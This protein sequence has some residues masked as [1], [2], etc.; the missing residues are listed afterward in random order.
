MAAGRGI[1]SVH[2]DVEADTSGV[3]QEVVKAFKSAGELGGKAAKDAIND[4]LGEIGG[5]KLKAALKKIREQIERGLD[6]LD[7]KLEFDEAKLRADIAKLNAYLERQDLDL[8]VDPDLENF[9]AELRALDAY[10][11]AKHPELKVD[12]TIESLQE[13]IRALQAR[14]DAADLDVEV[15]PKIDKTAKARTDAALKKNFSEVGRESGD[16]FGKNF[17]DSA[18]RGISTRWKAI[19]AGIATLMEPAAVLA[20]GLAASITSVLSSAVFAVGAG[21]AASTPLLVGLI[22]AI[23]GVVLA[24]EG[25][26]DAM[27]AIAEEDAEAFAAALEKLSPAAAEFATA[28][29]GVW[30]E[31]KTLRTGLQEDLFEGLADRFTNM[32]ESVIPQLEVGLGALV[33]KINEF[34]GSLMDMLAEADIGSVLEGLAPAIDLVLDGILSLASALMPFIEAATPAATQLAAMFKVWADNVADFD[35][36][37][38]QQFLDEGMDS[39]RLWLDLLGGV[40]S[41]LGT[42]FE[43]GK[44]SGDGFLQ[45]LNEI[46]DK[47]NE[48][49]TSVEGQSALEEFFENGR[50]VMAALEPLLVGLAQGIHN[51]V[52]EDSIARFEELTET[53]GEILPMV[54]TLFSLFS[55]MGILQGFADLLLVVMEALEPIVPILESFTD[56]ISEAIGAGIEAL[57]PAIEAFVDALAVLLP[58]LEPVIPVIFQLVTLKWQVIITAIGALVDVFAQLAPVVADLFTVMGP[59]IDTVLSTLG[60]VLRESAPLLEA[61]MKAFT[62]LLPAVEPLIEV[63][64]QLVSDVLVALAPVIT[65]LGDAL[66]QLMPS[67]VELIDAVRPIIPLLGE[68][69]VGAVQILMNLLEP[70]LPVLTDI[71]DAFLTA[72]AP[73]I[74]PLVDALVALSAALAPVIEELGAQM[75]EQIQTLAPLLPPLAELFIALLE[76]ITPLIPIVTDLLLVQNRLMTEGLQLIMPMLVDIIGIFTEFANVLGEVIATVTKFVDWVIDQFTRLFNVL[77]GNSIIPDLINGITEW[78]EKLMDLIDIVTA[79]FDG[80]RSVVETVFGAV[81]SFIETTINAIKS[82]VDSVWNTIKSLTQTAWNL[83]K[84]Y[85]VDPISSAWTT[86]SGL[87]DDI[88]SAVTGVWDSIKSTTTEVWNSIKDAILNPIETVKGLVQTEVDGIKNILAFTGLLGTVTGVFNSIKSA[89]VSPIQ[90]AY[91]AISGIVGRI[92]SAISSIPSPGGIVGKIG[93]LIPGAAGGMFTRPTPMVIGEA[94]R[95]AL[96]PLD[97][98]LNQID[99]SVRE[100]ASV[101]RGLKPGSGMT[102]YWNITESGNAEATAHKVL[103]RVLVNVAA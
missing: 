84:S 42:I 23:G 100:M 29:Q 40:S 6:D 49:L 70:L 44:E 65:E 73:V 97:R 56:A 59:F 22:G 32:A 1:G 90:A 75:A 79:V 78:F 52:S 31:F 103:N 48:W 17:T 93:G 10:I 94:G 76:A 77:V 19:I 87:V 54:G 3:R 27:S 60:D 55:N 99:P 15:E 30:E 33:S 9:F 45:S 67:F 98:P 69:L 83:I 37:K 41:A 24:M 89:M 102:N 101:L 36:G 43:A 16:L 14:L 71:A 57:A 7:I 20:E 63:L 25:M 13:E 39:L 5:P 26:G 4:E 88:E 28:V 64:G 50:R 35:A 95:E 11:D 85:I 62:K 46:V 2:V 92:K 91:D 81:K 86:V 61:L 66:V 21:A 68:L 8:E 38:L 47:F 82:V 12:V 96:I 74:P 58:A 72:L 51:M 18:G 80:I 53:I 34:A